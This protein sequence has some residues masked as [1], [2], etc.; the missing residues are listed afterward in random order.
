MCVN[1][2]LEHLAQP[3]V[4]CDYKYVHF[5][6]GQSKSARKSGVRSPCRIPPV[7][8]FVSDELRSCLHPTVS[9]KTNMTYKTCGGHRIDISSRG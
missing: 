2:T 8:A 9:Y 6:V 4:C 5:K 3:P 7:R 1:P